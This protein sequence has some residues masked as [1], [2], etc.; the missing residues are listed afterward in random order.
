MRKTFAGILIVLAGTGISLWAADKITLAD[1]PKH[2]VAESQLTVPGEAPFH[3][4]ARIFEKT[5][6]NNTDH[7]AEIEEFWVAPDKWRRT[8]KSHGFAEVL[9]ING[10]K[11][12]AQLDG[13][14]YPN[15]LR[16]IV[17]GLFDPGDAVQG[18]DLTKSHDTARGILNE[19]GML[20][21]AADSGSEVCR[22]FAFLAGDPPVTNRVFSTYCFENGRL[23]SVAAPGYSVSYAN[24]KKFADKQVARTIG[25]YLDPGTELEADVEVLDQLASPDEALFAVPASGPPLQTLFVNE[26][27][28]RSLILDAPEIRW[29]PMV[30]ERN[31]GVLS[32]Y[33]CVD[34]AGH[35]RETYALN[36]DNPH[37]SQVAREQMLKWS[38]RPAV[39]NDTGVQIE[40]VLTFG[41]QAPPF[42][43]P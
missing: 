2:A 32:I 20:I 19:Q 4:K 42:P 38:F 6:R 17:N 30:G 1:L 36:S 11:V 34:R 15:W 26:K 29:P 5:D 31:Y 40:S 10:G 7:D 3:L 16:A 22:R 18:I 33:V 39:H 24:Y 41:Y 28:L 9:V 43:N 21:P 25:E 12:G 35:V 8:V 13:D 23:E 27:T 14:Y 37:M